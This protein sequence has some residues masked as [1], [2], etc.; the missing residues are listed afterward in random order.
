MELLQPG[1]SDCGTVASG[2]GQLTEERISSS[3]LAKD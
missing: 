3:F 1:H 2:V